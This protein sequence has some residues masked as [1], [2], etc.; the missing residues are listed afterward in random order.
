MNRISSAVAGGIAGTAVMTL[1]LLLLE[2][3]TRSAM[4]VFYVIA[5]FV[6][7]PEDPATGFALFVGAGIV[8]WPLLFIALE[9]YL[10]RGPDPAARGVVFAAVLW[11]PFVI[12]GRGDIAGPLL[13][14]YVAYTLFAHVAYGFT[15][16]AVYGRLFDQL[17]QR[18]YR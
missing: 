12:L 10:P 17:R 14:F 18:G 15:L 11:V 4:D 5:L 1:M 8:A 13:I 6:G 16:G 7:T 3:E 2:V 9:P